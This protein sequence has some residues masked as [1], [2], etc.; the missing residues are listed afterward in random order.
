MID[1]RRLRKTERLGQRCVCP[2]SWLRVMTTKGD[3]AGVVA[4]PVLDVENFAFVTISYCNL[5]LQP[6]I[7]TQHVYVWNIIMLE[8]HQKTLHGKGRLIMRIL[9]A[10][11]QVGLPQ[12]FPIGHHL[13]ISTQ[14]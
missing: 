8:H 1:P 13:V 9:R 12:Q 4:D 11:V 10:V 2:A 5:C 7:V 14:Y 6:I 3:I